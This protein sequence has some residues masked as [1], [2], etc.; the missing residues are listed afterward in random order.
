MVR[1]LLNG[2]YDPRCSE[3]PS[4]HGRAA[5]VNGGWQRLTLQASQG[6]DVDA[7]GTGIGVLA[8]G[9]DYQEIRLT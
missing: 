8:T 1:D 3:Q 2:S 6:N 7:V 4:P 9:D 5:V